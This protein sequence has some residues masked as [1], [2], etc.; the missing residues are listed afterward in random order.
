MLAFEVLAQRF[1]SPV[2][3]V[4]TILDPSGKQIATNDDAKLK[5]E[6]FNKD[7]YLLHTFEKAG[8]YAVEVRNLFKTTGED[9]PYQLIVRPP[10][11][12]FELMLET[13]APYGPLK[14]S[15]ERK[16][17]YEKPIPIDV[18]GLAKAEIAAGKD[19]IEVP[20]EPGAPRQIRV[21]SG[22]KVA[23]RSVR[24]ASGGGEG[25]TSI[26]VEQATLTPAEKRWFS[27]ESAD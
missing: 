22:S 9:F 20:L 13:D 19:K 11:P 16:E 7:S 17:G 21:K 3:S 24:I 2:D 18:D 6:E 14:I 1:G 12:D 26:K 15:A 8:R 27:L 10:K 23:W 25:A 5:G 4:L